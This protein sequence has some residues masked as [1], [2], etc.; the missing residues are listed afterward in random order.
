MRTLRIREK[1]MRTHHNLSFNQCN[2]VVS[3][4]Q[5]IISRTETIFRRTSKG[6]AAA[7]PSVA[8]QL[9]QDHHRLLLLVNGFTSLEALSRI[10]PFSE[11][12]EHLALALEESGLIEEAGIPR[13][14]AFLR[15]PWRQSDH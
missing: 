14:E 12:P 7:M 8:P 6:Q 4:N 10:C 5:Q 2:G 15:S 1:S 9:S 3:M 13:S 11:G